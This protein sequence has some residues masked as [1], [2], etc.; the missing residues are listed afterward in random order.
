[1]QE[2]CKIN[3]KFIIYFRVKKEEVIEAL[4]KA[5]IIKT[6]N[7]PQCGDVLDIHFKWT[8]LTQCPS[9]K[10]SI[11]LEDAS[12]KLIGESSVLSPEPSL[13]KIHDPITIENKNYLPLGKIRYS[14]GRGFWEEW[15]LKG[16]KNREFWLSIDEGDFALQERVA[17]SLPF[18]SPRIVKAGKSY[19]LYV[20][21]EVGKGVCVGFEGELPLPIQIDQTYHYIHLSRGGGELVTVEFIDD[22]IE[23]FNGK[24]IDPLSIK[25]VYS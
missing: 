5:D 21:T 11:F 2:N 9:C 1:M 19:G 17:V 24:W 20:A 3:R 7:C 10:S 16:E 14:Y 23:T 8:K 12:V 6:L 22:K 15:F 25:R 4:Y 13:L 18:K